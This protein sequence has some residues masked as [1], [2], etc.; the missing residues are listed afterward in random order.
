MNVDADIGNDALA[1]AI[2]SKELTSGSA[3][4]ASHSHDDKHTHEHC[5]NCGA[6]LTGAYCHAC[7]QSAHIHRSLL[8]MTEEFLHGILH[9]D[10]KSWRTLPALIFRPGK[11][12]Y[13]YIHGQRTRYVSPLALFL[14]LI[15]LMFFVFSLTNSGNGTGNTINL[16]VDARNSADSVAKIRQEISETKTHLAELEARHSQLPAEDAGAEVDNEIIAVNAKMAALEKS[17]KIAQLIQKKQATPASAASGQASDPGKESDGESLAALLSEIKPDETAS[18]S[19]SWINQRLA[20]AAKNPDLTVYKMKSAASKFAFLLM[21]ISLPF[22]WLMFAFRRQF[23]MFDHAVFS[24]YSLSFMTLL[25]MLIVILNHF[26][27]SV[28]SAALFFIAPPLHMFSQL[29]GAYQLTVRESLWRTL[30]L[31]CIAST[32]ILL[33]ML[34]IAGLST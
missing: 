15:F 21:P 22:L 3:A 28:V 26:G 25:M 23:V 10:T 27:L 24:L 14:F 2:V 19:S 6:T 16:Q 20:H 32:S 9:F 17:L 11:L 30:A 13:D 34:L 33:Y 31:L 7:G 18:G 4:S 29:R 5:A 8:H 1:E 12:T